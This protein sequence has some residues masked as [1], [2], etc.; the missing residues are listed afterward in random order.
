M[1][2]LEEAI[3]CMCANLKKKGITGEEAEKGEDREKEGES[4]SSSF[5]VK[6]ALAYYGAFFARV[7]KAGGGI[8]ERIPQS[9][10]WKISQKA[11]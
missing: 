2:E 10:T 5:I 11:L 4:A 7:Q 1:D 8:G 6:N 3:E 9:G